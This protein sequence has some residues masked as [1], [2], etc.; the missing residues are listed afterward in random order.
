[1]NNS[2]WLFPQGYFDLNA[3]DNPAYKRARQ[4]RLRILNDRPAAFIFKIGAEQREAR[5]GNV[6]R[7]AY[8]GES[9]SCC[10]HSCR[11]LQR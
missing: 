3:N 9:S 8:L 2:H 7:K 1:M 4:D 5:R 10:K 6:P 11:G